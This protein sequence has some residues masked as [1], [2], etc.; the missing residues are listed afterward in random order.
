[1]WTKVGLGPQDQIFYLVRAR[2]GDGLL[3][4]RNNYQLWMWWQ[5][6]DVD[7]GGLWQTSTL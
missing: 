4:G 2:G 6:V 3:P 1:M 7:G 5:D